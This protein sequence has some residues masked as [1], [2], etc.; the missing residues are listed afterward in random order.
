MDRIRKGVYLND[1]SVWRH[2]KR[3]EIVLHLCG[4]EMLL[5]LGKD[6]VDGAARQEEKRKAKEEVYGCI[7]G[8]HAGG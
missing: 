8:R 1:S 2:S 6:D 5:V 4:G 7:E 3:G